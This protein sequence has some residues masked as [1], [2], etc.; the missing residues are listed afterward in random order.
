MTLG[1]NIHPSHPPPSR[2]LR[3]AKEKH[4][5]I[6]VYLERSSENLHILSTIHSTL[7]ESLVCSE[8]SLDVVQDKAHEVI[9]TANSWSYY[10]ALFR[11]IVA[12]K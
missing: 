1:F 3:V 7:S 5:L 12:C 4:L 2:L 8:S 10:L 11:E 6:S 9:C